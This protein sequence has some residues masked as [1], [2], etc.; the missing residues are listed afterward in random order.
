MK[1]INFDSTYYGFLVI[2]ND[3]GD[4]LK[5]EELTGCSQTMR[6]ISNYTTTGTVEFYVPNDWLIPIA[7]N[8]AFLRYWAN[9]AKEWFTDINY[10]GKFKIGETPLTKTVKDINTAFSYQ[11]EGNK[12]TES[13]Y[14]RN[15]GDLIMND[16]WRGFVIK[17]HPEHI[18]AKSTTHL[19]YAAYCMI[20]YL[21][22]GHFQPIITT[23]QYFNN[24]GIY[25]GFDKFKLFQMCHYISSLNI[26][27]ND[28]YGF[29]GPV[30]RFQNC[31][32]FAHLKSVKAHLRGAGNLNT[33]M[34][35]EGRS[36][37]PRSSIE[38]LI[39]DNKI[40][41]VYEKLS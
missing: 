38:L 33:A 12:I 25:N 7:R 1:K 14:I 35:M 2:K 41:E 37:H 10:L 26:A 34:Q 39:E 40:K 8:G 13:S 3:K 15:K 16:I 17:Q 31:F 29:I 18:G 4:I 6:T 32:K 20:R 24:L 30:A 23:Y 5:R 22:C 27:Y 9:L 28:K 21:F 19:T 11:Y 36:I